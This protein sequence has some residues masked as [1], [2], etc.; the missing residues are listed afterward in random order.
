M[1][2]PFWN[3]ANCTWWWPKWPRYIPSF[4]MLHSVAEN[5][6][7]PECANNTIRPKELEDFIIAMKEF[8]YTF[9]TFRDAIEKGGDRLVVLTFDDGYVDNYTY[10]FPILK[11]QSVP[12]TC[13][14]TNRGE[15]SPKFL[16][17]AMV[18]EMYDSGL[19]EFGGHTA[20][21]DVLTETSLEEARSSI[22][23]NKKW[24]EEILG[25]E[26]VS[27]CYPKGR[28]ND[29]IVEVVKAAGYKYAAAMVKKMRPVEADLYRIHRQIL[30]RGKKTY[31]LYLLATRGK[32][33]I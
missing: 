27:F 14:I 33:K 1:K 21:H 25:E 24:I 4:V 23:S 3:L 29:D 30:P 13:F 11:R 5:P 18:K 15:S 32:Y 17:K 7:D 16:S 28:E 12:A 19:V 26:I 6:V 20:G 31:E 10:L 2:L 9:V 22:E 8:G